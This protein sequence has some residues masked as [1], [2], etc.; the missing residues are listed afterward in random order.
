MICCSSRDQGQHLLARH[1]LASTHLES[2]ERLLALLVR[3]KD[4]TLNQTP[5][6]LIP[7]LLASKLAVHLLHSLAR[8]G[9]VLLGL[10]DRVE[11]LRVGLEVYHE[12]E[13]AREPWLTGKGGEDREEAG[14]GGDLQRLGEGGDG[15]VGAL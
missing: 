14:A 12:R 15:D 3:K 11:V 10:V 4:D 5:S 9:N 7:L 6:N 2:L 13:G 8:S 1:D